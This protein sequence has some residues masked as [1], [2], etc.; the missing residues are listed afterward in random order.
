MKSYKSIIT[1]VFVILAVFFTQFTYPSSVN[2]ANFSVNDAATLISAIN[3]A[4]TNLEDDVITL[5]ANIILTVADNG[6]INGLPIILSDGGSR[7]TIEGAG[8]TISR[9]STSNFRILEINSGANLTL[10]NLTISNGNSGA[11]GGGGIYINNNA[12]VT[13]LNST[14]TNNTSNAGFAGGAIY[15]S[16]SLNITGST[17]SGNSGTGFSSD[18]GAIFSN[19]AIN[20][21]NSTFFGNT[22]ATDGSGGTGGAIRLEGGFGA[23]NI[24]PNI[25]THVTFS[26][27]TND[28]LYGALDVSNTNAILRSSILANTVTGIDCSVRNGGSLTSTNNLIENTSGCSA[29]LTGDPILGLL[30]NNEG[31]T[32]TMALLS[33]SPAIDVSGSCATAVDQRGVTR[34]Q[35]TG[36]NCDI[37]SY[38]LDSS[39]P[40]LISFTRQTPAINPTNADTL[41]FRATFS[42]A[43]QNV[44]TADFIVNGTTTATVSNVAVVSTSVYDITVSGG[45]LASFNGTVGLNLAGGQNIQD[46]AGNALPA[47][48]PT[49]DETYTVDNSV[50][51]ITSFT[52]QLPA[53]T[54]T[55]ADSLVFRVTFSEA[56]QNVDTTDFAVNGTTTATISTVAVVSTSIYDVTVSGGDLASFNGIVG[57]NL[58]GGQNIQDLAGNALPAGEPSTDETY[59][60]DNTAL[61][62]TSFTRQTP[63]TSPTNA[64]TLVFRATF[65]EAVQNVDTADFIVNGTTTATVSNVAVVST[66]IYDITVSGGDL[67]SFNGTVGL[68]LAGGQNIRDLAGNA[69]SAGEPAT[70]ETYTINN[71]APIVISTGLTASYTGTGPSSFTVTFNKALDD[72]TGNTGVDDVTNPANYLLINKGV[73][74]TADTTSCGPIPGTGGIKPDDGQIT[75]IG[76]TYDNI[77]FT[78]TVTLASTLPIGSYRLFICGT[79]SIVDLAG[80]PLNGGTDYTFDFVVQASTQSTSQAKIASIPAT[81]F[82]MNQVISLPSQPAKL[83]Y[84]STDLWLEIPTLNVKMSIVGVP[85]TPDGWDVTWLD[86]NAGWL[87]GSAFPTWN[88]NSVITA[89]VWDALNR[90]GPFAKLK[91][92]KYGDQIKIHAFGQVYI[93]EIRESTTISP[94]N[95]SAMLKHE[96]KSWITLVTCE[97]Y[98]E[99]S[100]TYS[101]RRM[102]RAILVKVAAK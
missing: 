67:A 73:N 98:I 76:V 12:V 95:V 86:K 29:T 75:V 23:P 56:V 17:F 59:T 78:S 83:A 85:S 16:G 89:H 100:K 49:T 11:A 45:D 84:T 13:I 82:P 33:G 4:N 68:D 54:P 5:T 20:I 94:N 41:V 46:L 90:P 10:N 88:G 77:T 7:L 70:D 66:S 1:P 53:T 57:L 60:V 79:T 44:D 21:T 6:G 9:S 71:L 93:Y 69:L 38:E 27:N 58:A 102:V 101:S 63:A 87:N 8:F 92:L 81:G 64:D 2:A 99:K 37:G 28:A 43:V 39:A 24:G 22:A 65:S 97:D 72:P 96:E 35:P 19:N 14:F 26:N 80:N 55:N 50:P 47:G 31:P 32:S 52:R 34:P 36:G 51:S 74:G 18:G 40:S 15:N 91:N 48:E 42:E 3:T 25:I 61:S 30:Q 62:I